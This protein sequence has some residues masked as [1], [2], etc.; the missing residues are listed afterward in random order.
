[1]SLFLAIEIAIGLNV[2]FVGIFAL[3]TYGHYSYSYEH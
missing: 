2:I 3:Q 1:M